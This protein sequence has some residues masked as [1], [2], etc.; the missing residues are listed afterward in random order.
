MV[1]LLMSR[2]NMLRRLRLLRLKNEMRRVKPKVILRKPLESMVDEKE[3]PTVRKVFEK[4]G[5]I[6]IKILGRGLFQFTPHPH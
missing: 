2:K 6:K 4:L 1:L 3:K 5:N